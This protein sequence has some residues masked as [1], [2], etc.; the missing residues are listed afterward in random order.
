MSPNLQTTRYWKTK[1]GVIIIREQGSSVQIFSMKG[2]CS[3]LP[4]INKKFKL[5]LMRCTKAYSSS[6]HRLV[7]DIDLCRSP[8][9]PKNPSNPLFWHL[10]SS[11]VIEFGANWEP[12]YNFLLV[13]NSNL[14]PISHRYWDTVTYWPKI[15]NF[16]HPPHLAPSFGV[17]PFKF[18]KKLY[19]S[20]N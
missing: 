1:I 4:D 13:I 7:N 9:L 2:W 3:W 17:T 14:G 19:G 10:R 20:W 6:W 8:K 12:V 18:M 5:M 11:K 16:A 15:A